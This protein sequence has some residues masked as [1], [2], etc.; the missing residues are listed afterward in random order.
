M[1]VPLPNPPAS[2]RLD[3]AT[4][5]EQLQAC[6]IRDLGSVPEVDVTRSPYKERLAHR[7][8]PVSHPVIAKIARQWYTFSDVHQVSRNVVYNP[9]PGDATYGMSWEDRTSVTHSVELSA[10]V[11]AGI[12]GIASVS[13]TATMGT[14]WTS[15]HAEGENVQVQILPGY[16][17]WIDRGTLINNIEGEFIWTG[18]NLTEFYGSYRFHPFIGDERQPFR[19]KGVLTGPGQVASMTGVLITSQQKADS[20]AVQGIGNIPTLQQR[21]GL[22]VI[23]EISHYALADGNTVTHTVLEG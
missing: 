12:E 2:E 9:G 18:G 21:D 5:N 15:E 10:T 4:F 22:S 13:M 8:S 3:H 11:T 20:D 23:P 6:G 1:S 14:S 16:F 7:M 17:G 19:W